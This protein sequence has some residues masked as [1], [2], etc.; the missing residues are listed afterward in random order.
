MKN[1]DTLNIYLAGACRHV[2]DE[3]KEWREQIIERLVKIAEWSGVKIK[4]INPVEKFS[5]S[6]NKHKTQKQ[7]KDYFLNKISKCDLVIVNCND[8][9]DSCGTCMEVQFAVDH[10]IPCIG[11]GNKNMYEWVTEVDCQV[12]F[13]TMSE[14]VDYVRDYYMT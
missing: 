4:V 2:L 12:V 8:T 13:D 9:A 11:F 6:S 10:N 14:A 1:I 3:G 7:V 5:Y